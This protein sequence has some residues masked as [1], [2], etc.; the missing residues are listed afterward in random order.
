MVVEETW[1]FRAGVVWTRNGR[2]NKSQRKKAREKNGTGGK[3]L[4]QPAT[5]PM[6]TYERQYMPKGRAPKNSP[7]LRDVRNSRKE[8]GARQIQVRVGG[9]G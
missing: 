3:C 2:R 6:H 8:K 9:K 5:L 4:T 1:I 7:A